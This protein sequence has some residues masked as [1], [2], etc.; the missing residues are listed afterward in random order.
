[1]GFAKYGED[2]VSRYVS[3]RHLQRSRRPAAG[4]DSGN[5]QHRAKP[6][7]EEKRFQFKRLDD[8]YKEIDEG[9]GFRFTVLQLDDKSMKVKSDITFE[10]RQASF[11]YNFVRN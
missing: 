9:G 7:G 11:V 5:G 3:D 1:M 6:K 2:I 8:K 4:P 10:G